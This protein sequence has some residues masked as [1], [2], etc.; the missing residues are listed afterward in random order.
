M[1]RYIT[2]RVTEDEHKWL[3]EEADRQQRSMS[4]LV[5]LVLMKYRQSLE[6]KKDGQN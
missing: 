2:I 1:T 4:N 6:E 5:R 3:A